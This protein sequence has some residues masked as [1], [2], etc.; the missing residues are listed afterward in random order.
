MPEGLRVITSLVLVQLGV[1]G[2]CATL[3]MTGGASLGWTVFVGAGVVTLLSGAVW[4]G[5]HLRSPPPA[6]P[7]PDWAVGHALQSLV[8]LL[9]ATLIGFA[10]V[11]MPTTAWTA[12]LAMLY[13]VVAL[14]GFLSQI[15]IGMEQW[16][17]PF[18]QRQTRFSSS[19]FADQPPS[20]HTMGSQSIRAVVF[21]FWT[22]GVP[23]FATGM[24]VEQV[25][26]V[27]TGGWALLVALLLHTVN[28][29]RTLRS[30]APM[31][32]YVGPVT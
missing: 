4:M 5:R 21:G 9:I 32:D 30:L 6:R 14:L 24:A 8:Y 15:I 28:T 29:V 3:L 20:P 10:L 13:G 1:M 7:Q 19:G 11:L 16:I 31:T 23:V 12:R 27:G 26:V 18:F 17:L 22:V 2:M 25:T